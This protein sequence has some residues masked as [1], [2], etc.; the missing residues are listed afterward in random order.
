MVAGL[1]RTKT[2]MRCAFILLAAFAAS[3]T[4]ASPRQFDL[5]CD[6]NTGHYGAAGFSAIVPWHKRYAVDLDR[7]AF[8]PEGCGQISPL[9][10]ESGSLTV[11]GEEA[12]NRAD[13][14]MIF[15]DSVGQAIHAICVVAPFTPFPANRF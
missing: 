2:P 12:V 10:I 3:P 1:Q 9:G 6:G 5:V 8:C 11:F 4:A 14:T 13:G 7:A 15:V